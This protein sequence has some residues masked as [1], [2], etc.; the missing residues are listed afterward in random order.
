MK[1][2]KGYA[3]ILMIMLSFAAAVNGIVWHRAVNTN[4]I[5][6]G[7]FNIRD[8]GE[9]YY[10]GTSVTSTAAEL[11][12]ADGIA[13]VIGV[14]ASTAHMCTLAVGSAD[15]VTDVISMYLAHAD[16]AYPLML[17]YAK[18]GTLTVRRPGDDIYDG[19]DSVIALVM[20]NL[21]N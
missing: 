8:A 14:F 10:S 20:P 16:S 4:I 1:N 15:S 18:A 13:Q 19:I 2:L 5:Q 11:N 7:A 9:L 17:R 6:T 12:M 21:G 3:V